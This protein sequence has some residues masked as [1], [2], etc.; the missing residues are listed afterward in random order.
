MSTNPPGS[1]GTPEP[2][3][4]PKPGEI[5]GGRAVPEKDRPKKDKDRR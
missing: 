4:T 1:G 3:P 5:P 2:P